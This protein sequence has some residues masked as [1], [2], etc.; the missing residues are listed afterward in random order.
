MKTDARIIVNSLGGLSEIEPQNP[1]KCS[2]LVNV[3]VDPATQGWDTRIGWEPLDAN[4]IGTSNYEAF[5]DDN[6][7]LSVFN[8]ATHGGAKPILLWEAQRVS[9][10]Y[11]RLYEFQGNPNDAVQLDAQ[12][13]RLP[14]QNDYGTY[15]EPY[16]RYLVIL[17]GRDRP[18][19]YDGIKTRT[20]GFQQNPSPPNPWDINSTTPGSGEEPDRTQTENINLP[21]ATLS[22]VQAS[23]SRDL[24]VNYGLGSTTENAQNSFRYKLTWVYENG[25]ESPISPRSN[26]VA[27][28]TSST[29]RKFFIWLDNIP[30]GPEGVVARRLYR[31]K[32]LGNNP[33]AVGTDTAVEEEVYYFLDQI[34]NNVDETYFDTTPDSRLGSLAPRDD[35]SVVFPARTARF[36]ATFKNCLFLDGGVGEGGVVYYSVPG[37]PDQF[38]ALDFFNVGTGNAG[39]VKALKAFYDNL[40]VFRERGI[41]I[42]TGDPLNGFVY[43]P[44]VRGYGCKSPN[45]VVE[46][47]GIGL[48]FL[49]D[50]GIYVLNGG[51]KGGEKLSINKISK[52]LQE[53]FD[54]MNNS[55]LH[56]SCAAYSP[57]W[58][59]VHFYFASDGASINNTGV[60][61]HTDNL[62]FS[63][64]EGFPVGC[65]T[66]NEDGEFIFGVNAGRT[67]ANNLG[68]YQG[69][70]YISHRR[71]NG[72]KRQG[73]TPGTIQFADEQPTFEIQSAEHTF[74]YAGQQ[75]HPKYLYLCLMSRGNNKFIVDLFKNRDIKTTINVDGLNSQ[76]ADVEN[77]KIYA[78]NTLPSLQ[79]ME[80]DFAV[81]DT[82]VWEKSG[83]TWVRYD[84]A[85]QGG[86][87]QFSFKLSGQA[88]LTLLG[89]VIEF[90]ATRTKTRQGGTR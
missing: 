47:P 3:C 76:L 43:T 89:Y 48:M 79:G 18:I 40:I 24:D 33:T 88:D 34:D 19:L 7:V 68:Q 58:K 32:N 41:D 10:N 6:V 37:A 75:K 29:T 69:L 84:I 66:T 70:Y 9:F 38:R 59:E 35:H 42:I 63:T 65:I 56:K 53:V 49:S 87:S 4:I 55:M 5:N 78:N 60:V 85:T 72:T 86:C 8:W 16:G 27:W 51:L 74:G 17:N 36:A 12:D 44:F 1:E 31:T 30:R 26:P 25:S 73:S 46:V 45:A 83:L 82:A 71:T 77:Q 22:A 67:S 15:Y 39:D 21:L 64:R 50:D 61:F 52:E 90:D 20:L 23:Y 11:S 14:A 54:R 57:L 62:E 13:R 28:K 81:F 2:K 80:N